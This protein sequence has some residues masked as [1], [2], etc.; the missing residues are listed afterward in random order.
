MSGCCGCW[1]VAPTGRGCF[2]A[3]VKKVSILSVSEGELGGGGGAAAV[4]GGSVAGVPTPTE[5]PVHPGKSSA[6]ASK[7]VA[8]T[9]S[10]NRLR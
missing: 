7:A 10:H 8:G 6:S 1:A 9:R 4:E 5:L 2:A 3:P